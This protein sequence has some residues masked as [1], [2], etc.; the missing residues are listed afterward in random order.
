MGINEKIVGIFWEI[1]IR[2]LQIKAL[3]KRALGFPEEKNYCIKT[4][5]KIKKELEELNR[6]LKYE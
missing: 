4:I 3:K 2:Q 1:S 6:R 5:E